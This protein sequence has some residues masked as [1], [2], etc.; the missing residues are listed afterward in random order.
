MSKV[1]YGNFSM[2]RWASFYLVSIFVI[3]I[4]SCAPDSSGSSINLENSTPVVVSPTSTM[5]STEMVEPVLP[6]TYTPLEANEK[7][8]PI[9]K[10]L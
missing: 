6:A 7:I 4:S 10:K 1:A 3:F 2:A 9:Y 5:A 8:E